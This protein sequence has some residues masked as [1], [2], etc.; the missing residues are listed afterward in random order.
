MK[1]YLQLFRDQAFSAS[2][3][4]FK[5]TFGSSFLAM[6]LSGIIAFLV[7][8]PLT[9]LAIGYSAFD[10]LKYQQDLQSIQEDML[11]SGASPQNIMDAYLNMFHFSIGLILLLVAVALFIYGWM[12]N[13]MY[14]ISD[15]E[16]RKGSPNFMES[17][18]QSFNFN[19]ILK[20]VGFFLLFGLI[21]IAAFAIFALVSAMIISVAK[22]IGILLMFVG[23]LFLIVFF[24][25]FSIAIPAMV[26][27]KKGITES[28][29][30]SLSHLNWKRGWMILLLCFITF[31]LLFIVTWVLM[32]AFGSTNTL[33]TGSF[34]GSQVVSLVINALF[35]TYIVAATSTLYFRYSD[36]ST[37]DDDIQQHIIEDASNH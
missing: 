27:G 19:A 29:S 37:E 30:F 35:F 11:T 36:D 32:L 20:I 31:I 16:I 6:L 24:L 3:T 5:R 14:R 21:E 33:T 4:L 23:F 12:T 28:I 10:M 22:G 8:M 15:N 9:M 17:L 2:L 18:K 1:H 7:I 34:I 26:H 13:F 25:R